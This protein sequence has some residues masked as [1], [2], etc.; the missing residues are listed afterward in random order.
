MVK[1]VM[2]YP[3]DAYVSE[4]IRVGL[5]L[6][7]DKIHFGIVPKGGSSSH[8]DIFITNMWDY[9]I[10]VEVKSTGELKGWLVYNLG[11]FV[12]GSVANGY[13]NEDIYLEPGETT[14]ITIAVVPP[15]YTVEDYQYDGYIKF[16]IKRAHWF[17]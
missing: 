5:N 8:R 9:D 16:I 7:K 14:N 2:S 11:E 6:D 1:D 10:E 17:R 12:N 3:S 4:T 13:N 15:D